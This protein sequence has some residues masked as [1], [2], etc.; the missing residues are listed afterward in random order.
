MKSVLRNP[1]NV[2]DQISLH[3]AQ[4]IEVIN[5]QGRS[6]PLAYSGLSFDFSQPPSHGV[7]ELDVIECGLGRLA[8][9]NEKG[10]L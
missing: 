10:H 9:D 6:R 3:L 5:R 7:L 8:K 4:M 2:A 1:V